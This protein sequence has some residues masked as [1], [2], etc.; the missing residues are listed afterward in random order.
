MAVKGEVEQAMRY[1][2]E[3]LTLMSRRGVPPTPENYAVW[4]AYVTGTNGDLRR[5]VDLLIE[6]DQ[7]FDRFRSQSLFQ[8][9]VLPTMAS[10]AIGGAADDLDSIVYRLTGMVGE[11]GEDAARYGEALTNA[12]TNLD[13]AK[14]VAGIQSVVASLMAETKAIQEKN[15]SLQ[16]RLQESADEID[17]LRQKL[18][19]SRREAETDGLTG[20]NNRKRFDR[21][22]RDLAAAAIENDTSLCLLMID[23]DHFKKFNDNFGHQLGDQVLKL[24][25]KTLTECVRDLDV[26]ARYGGE[27]FSVI[28]PKSD[29]DIAREIGDRIRVTVGAKRIIKRSTGEDLGTITLSVGAGKYVLGEAVTDLIKRAD[30]ALYLAKRSGRNQVLTEDDHAN[31]D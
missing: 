7:E 30:E 25:A 12:T 27:E 16:D 4:Y 18:E 2:S 26:P 13:T 20:I 21:S 29:L 1:A 31:A 11:A 5:Q 22:L 10:S 3:V 8:D 23:I 15:Q 28:L 19:D 6:N 9:Y 14:G 17:G 24:V